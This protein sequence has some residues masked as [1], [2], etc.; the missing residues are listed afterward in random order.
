MEQ[1]MIAVFCILAVLLDVAVTITLC[2]RS[3]DKGWA[4]G[5]AIGHYDGCNSQRGENRVATQHAYRHELYSG[6]VPNP[7]GLLT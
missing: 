5:Y 7:G 3:R 6:K 1:V 2:G 4:E